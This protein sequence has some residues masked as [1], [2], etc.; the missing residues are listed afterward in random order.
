[1]SFVLKIVYFLLRSF[2][3]FESLSFYETKDQKM[4]NEKV[5]IWVN[6]N[7]KS[8]VSILPIEKATEAG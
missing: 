8:L 5:F 6:I 4:F 3:V 7:E 2:E 1:M